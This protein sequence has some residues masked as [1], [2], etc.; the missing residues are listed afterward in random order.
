[1]LQ[2]EVAI[3]MEEALNTRHS[4]HHFIASKAF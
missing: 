2:H 1:M 4:I 3:G